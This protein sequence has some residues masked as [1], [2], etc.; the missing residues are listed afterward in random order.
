MGGKLF[1]T[2]IGPGSEGYLTPDA[3]Q[4]LEDADIIVGYSVY[5]KLLPDRFSSKEIYA[6]GMGGETERCRYAL[7]KAAEGKN[8][9]VI[10]SGD[11]G[12]YGMAS[13]IYDLS[14]GIDD[15]VD[16]TVVPGITAALSGAARLG[17]PIGNDFA[18]ISLSTALTEWDDI[19]RRLDLA[20]EGDFA[21]VLYN[22]MSR[23]RQDTL[24]MACDIISK[25]TGNDRASG[26][27]RNIGRTGEEHAVLTVGELRDAE[28]DMFTT[29]FIGNSTTKITGGKMITG[30]KYRI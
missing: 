29:V 3:V 7:D 20:S 8:V 2:G 16:I 15:L 4:S 12:V 24:K 5:I 28:L 27:V 1:V 13:L 19:A 21:I 9:T 14:S 17:A 11:P 22:P 26:Y 6:T 25:H 23:T 30:R 10:C 18:V